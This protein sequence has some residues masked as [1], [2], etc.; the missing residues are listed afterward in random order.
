MDESSS[1]IPRARRTNEIRVLEEVSTELNS[2]HDLER[3]LDL[4]MDTMERVFGVPHCSV[5]LAESYEPGAARA[6]YGATLHLAARR[7]PRGREGQHVRVGSGIVGAA[8]AKGEIVRLNFRKGALPGADAGGHVESHMAVPMIAQGTLVGVLKLETVHEGVLSLADGQLAAIVANQAAVA[9]ENARLYQRQ[10]QINVELEQRVRE[11]TAE[12]EQRHRE[13]QQA[14]AELVQSS[15]LAALGQ[16]AAGLTHEI[17]TPLG[18]INAS[19]DTA[20]KALQMLRDDPSESKS[21]RALAA[22]ESS[23]G[24]IRDA[25]ERVG[26]VFASLRRFARLDESELQWVDLHDGLDATLE[27]LGHRT[28]AGVH[29][30]RR[31]SELPDVLCFAGEINQVLLAI[32]TNA[33]DAL[34]ARW[35][36]DAS[37]PR[38]LSLTTRVERDD[39]YVDVEDN[40]VGIAPE[41]LEHIFD[42]GF[43]TKGTRVGAGMS[44][45]SAFRIMEKHGGA[46]VVDSAARRGTRVT[47]RLPRADAHDARQLVMWN[48]ER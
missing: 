38:E 42:P 29:V 13:L 46:I 18:A 15:K 48:K 6:P 17:N 26:G 8:A 34:E 36:D 1:P 37:R 43:S 28:S 32:I 33:L 22:L 45:A 24:L 5:F 27:L 11:R 14:Q 9:I 47:L 35:R 21:R 25:T 41:K 30:A 39:V 23:H 10:Q 20:Y 12:L 40:G 3:L 4:L 19:I 2:V 44:L 16:L 31:Y 7:G